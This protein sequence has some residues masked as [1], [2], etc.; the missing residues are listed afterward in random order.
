MGRAAATGAPVNV[1]QDMSEVTLDVVLRALFGDDLARLTDGRDGNPFALLTDDTERNLA[2]A[3]K[4]RQLGKPILDDVERRRRDGVA[5]HDIVS[6]LIDARD[7]QTGEPMADR[8]LLDEIMTL[9]VAGH[10]TTASSLNWFWYLLTPA[11]DVGAHA[12][13]RG[14]R[15]RRRRRP[16]YDDLADLPLRAARDRRDAAAVSAWLAADAPLDRRGH[17]SA[18]SRCRRRPMS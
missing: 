2:F 15:R 18:A 11:P 13:R 3:Y 16:A 10:E 5:A 12:P 14:R 7:R 1:T 6:Q 17:A 9:I 4:F 8:Q